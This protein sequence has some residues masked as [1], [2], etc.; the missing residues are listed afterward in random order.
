M[1]ATLQTNWTTSSTRAFMQLIQMQ[2]CLVREC[3]GTRPSC[4]K[5]EYRCR[6]QWP[7]CQFPAMLLG[8]Y[9]V[10]NIL[11][12][13]A[14][15]TGNWSYRHGSRIWWS[16]YD[17]YPKNWN[18]FRLINNGEKFMIRDKSRIL[19]TSLANVS[20]YQITTLLYPGPIITSEVKTDKIHTVLLYIRHYNPE[21]NRI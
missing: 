10:I 18:F 19:N 12:E 15:R 20:I 9:Q 16:G 2:N 14:T 8:N 13:L 21:E 4:W 17:Y 6:R 3:A 1:W 11:N 5:P 7:R